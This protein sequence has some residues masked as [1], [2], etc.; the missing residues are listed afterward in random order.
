MS[1]RV[2]IRNWLLKPSKAELAD[3]D[4]QGKVVAELVWGHVEREWKRNV[5]RTL[6]V[7]A[8]ARGVV[9]SEGLPVGMVAYTQNAPVGVDFGEMPVG[10]DE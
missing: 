10:S 2:I 9:F 7:D 8:T 1:L 5:V 4:G 6:G 3:M